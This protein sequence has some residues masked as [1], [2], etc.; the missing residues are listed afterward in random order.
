MLLEQHLV[1][2]KVNEKTSHSGVMKITPTLA[3]FYHVAPS[4][5]IFHDSD[6]L[7]NKTTLSDEHLENFHS[8][9]IQ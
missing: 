8:S 7:M 2:E 4:K 9:R 6:I 5:N 3:L 1:S